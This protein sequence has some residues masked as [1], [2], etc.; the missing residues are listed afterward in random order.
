MNKREERQ[1]KRL[2]EEQRK[3]NISMVTIGAGLLL[4]VAGVFLPKLNLGKN[5]L[6]N[7]IVIPNFHERS[8]GTENAIGNPDATVKVE[9]FSSFTCSHCAAFALDPIPESNTADSIVIPTESYLLEHYIDTGKIYF[10]YYPYGWTDEANLASEAAF[11]AMEQGKFWDYRDV[12]FANQGNQAIDG[13]SSASLEAFAEKI[14]MNT[15]QFNDC[16]VNKKYH[17]KM[18]EYNSLGNSRGVE[19]T[20][21]FIVN[22]VNVYASDLIQTIENA[23]NK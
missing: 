19:G 2:K 4:V 7:N 16:F 1:Q 14:S 11:C 3:K 8:N 15:K 23:L 10:I 13:F 22:D 6:L 17:Q 5:K 12:V 9:E 21:T 18:L 20:P